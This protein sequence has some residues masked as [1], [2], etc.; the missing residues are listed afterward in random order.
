MLLNHKDDQEARISQAIEAIHSNNSPSIRATAR[1]YDVSHSTLAKCLCEQ[2]T[3][4]QS[5]MTNQKLLHTEEEALFQWVIFMSKWGFSTRISAV[6]KMAD[7]LLSAR[8]EFFVNASLTVKENWVHKFVNR[9]EQLQSKY[10]QKYNYQRALCEDLKVM[11]NWFQLVKNTQAKY[12]ISNKD[13][14]NFDKTGF[15]MRVIDTV[16]VITES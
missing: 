8:T 13:I 14:Y 12:G 9:H 15:Q 6:C 10:T 4:Q 11:S 3:Y 1:V 5:W 7:I 16:K 2:P